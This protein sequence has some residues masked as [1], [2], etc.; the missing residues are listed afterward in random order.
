MR[1]EIRKIKTKY[2]AQFTLPEFDDIK[3]LLDEIERL[4]LIEAIHNLESAII[5]DY[6][7]PSSAMDPESKIVQALVRKKI[8]DEREACARIAEEAPISKDGQI[9]RIC[10]TIS[11][12]IRARK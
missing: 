6:S 1:E 4:D 10:Q 12:A 2:E 11:K 9:F 5:S 3:S 7:I 8:L